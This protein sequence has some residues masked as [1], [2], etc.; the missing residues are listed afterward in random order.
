MIQP[1]RDTGRHADTS[2]TAEANRTQT[3]HDRIEQYF[4][5]NAETWRDTYAA[6]RR[7]ADHVLQYRKQI[8]VDAVCRHATPGSLVLDAGCGAG[9]TALDLVRRQFRVVGIDIAPRMIAL[10]K[11]LFSGEEVPQDSFDFI[12]AELEAAS[13]PSCAFGAIVALGFLQ[14]QD[15]E[16]P[17]LLRLRDLLEPGGLLVVSGPTEVKV[18]NYFGLPLYARRALTALGVLAPKI[19]PGRV[20]RHKYSVSRFR[21]LLGDA[22]FDVLEW[23]GHGFAEFDY[24]GRL[25]PFPVEL[26]VHRALMQVARVT[27]L[28][29]W[30]NDLVFVARRPSGE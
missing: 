20:G 16:E 10:S 25:M 6:P 3:Q 26:A 28:G 2:A 9:L 24:V 5:A 30:G 8:A 1:P 22:G 23:T 14:Y 21:H 19:Y 27:P 4:D 11:E 12:E 17:V 18:A 29:R 15:A 13:L 7:V